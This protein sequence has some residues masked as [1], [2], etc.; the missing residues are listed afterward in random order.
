MPQLH[1]TL[2]SGQ[3][4]LYAWFS[5]MHTR[6]DVLLKGADQAALPNLQQAV[7]EVRATVARLEQIGNKFDAASELSHFNRCPVGVDFAVSPELHHMITLCLRYNAQTEGLFDVTVGSANHTPTTI[8]KLHASKAHEACTLRRD[9]ADVQIDLSGFIKG[10]ALDCIR[11]VLQR[12]GITDALINMGNSSIMAMGDVP[13]TVANGCL[14]T[15]GN[16]DAHRRHIMNPLTGQMM[17]GAGQV[18]VE[19]VSGAEG[20]ALATARFILHTLNNHD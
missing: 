7:D 2:P 12:R 1:R 11:P 10:Y 8:H 20:E 14:T 3:I 17:E 5:A 16:S 15:S 18:S 19:T 6:V 4:A 13:F 9:D